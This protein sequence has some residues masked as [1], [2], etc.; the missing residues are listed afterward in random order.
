MAEEGRIGG[1]FSLRGGYLLWVLRTPS[2]LCHG[3]RGNSV[4]KTPLDWDDS[5]DFCGFVL[6][7]AGLRPVADEEQRWEVDGHELTVELRLDRQR[8]I[9][10]LWVR[11]GWPLRPVRRSPLCLAEVYGMTLT[12]SVREFNKPEIGWFKTKAL[13]DSGLIER[14]DVALVPLPH[15]APSTAHQT[16]AQVRELYEVRVAQGRGSQATPLVAPW[17]AS[18]NGT[19]QAT[20]RAGKRWLE[21]Q[22]FITHVDD[23]PGRF[24]RPTK[25]WSLR[26]AA[27]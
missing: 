25:L 15:N 23:G 7:A 20:V 13:I 26:R 1:T 19:D 2:L 22:G 14:P 21:Q 17:M 8:Y 4:R 9:Y 11:A 27:A 18:W 12:L 5:A 6:G 3:I 16:W 24:G 10:V